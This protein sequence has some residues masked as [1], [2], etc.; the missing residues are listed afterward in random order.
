[1]RARS[2]ALWGALTSIIGVDELLLT[3][4]LTLIV[5]ALW[6]VIGRIALLVPG[7]CLLYVALP[8]R[9]PFLHQPPSPDDLRRKR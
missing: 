4:A 3:L 9:S 6:P 5:V 8:Q 7:V 2:L 1:M